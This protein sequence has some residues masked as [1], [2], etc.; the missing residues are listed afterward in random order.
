[1]TLLPPSADGAAAGGPRLSAPRCA[2]ERGRQRAAKRALAVSERELQR[3]RQHG[4]TPAG[5]A[6][7]AGRDAIRPP[8]L[9]ALPWPRASRHKES[10]LE[11]DIN[12]PRTPTAAARGFTAPFE[13]AG[14]AREAG[15]APPRA[16][17]AAAHSGFSASGELEHATFQPAPPATYGAAARGE[18][19]FVVEAA[20][21]GKERGA[22]PP[23]FGRSMQLACMGAAYDLCHY[24]EL[25]DEMLR[26]EG[27]ETRCTFIVARQGRLRPLLSFCLCSLLM[28]CLIWF[29]LRG[30]L[31]R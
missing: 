11:D 25:T 29:T 21:K 7:T 20:G 9:K 27:F 4:A 14:G 31:G 6:A 1:M 28:A 5:A 22:A 10:D 17:Y 16:Q 30:L 24:G 26:A 2:A 15:G 3:L 18:A 12:D 19:A 23:S 13:S 8:N